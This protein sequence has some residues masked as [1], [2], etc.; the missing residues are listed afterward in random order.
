[1]WHL[2]NLFLLGGAALTASYK[3]EV[4]PQRVLLLQDSSLPQKS[5]ARDAKMT[6]FCSTTLFAPSLPMKIVPYVPGAPKPKSKSKAKSLAT[7][8]TAEH[9]RGVGSSKDGGEWLSIDDFPMLDSNA[10]PPTLFEAASASGS[11]DHVDAVDGLGAASELE[12]LEH[13]QFGRESLDDGGTDHVACIT[14]ADLAMV[15]LLGGSSRDFPLILE[16][17]EA[18]GHRSATDVEPS[19]G[20]SDCQENSYRAS[21]GNGGYSAAQHGDLDAVGDRAFSIEDVENICPDSPVAQDEPLLD[22]V[23]VTDELSATRK[24]TRPAALDVMPELALEDPRSSKRRR[25]A[26]RQV[27]K[28]ILGPVATHKS[29]ALPT[30]SGDVSRSRASN[31]PSFGPLDSGNERNGVGT[32]RPSPS[33]LRDDEDGGDSAHSC[34][35]SEEL[36]YS[37]RGSISPSERIEREQDILSDSLGEA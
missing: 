14:E 32:L 31:E 19:N 35:T 6:S 8:K 28:L 21:A 37:L 30:P 26:E 4:R 15:R 17:D 9:S 36:L 23:D 29:T 2:C 7:A 24:G 12:T 1:M 25:L 11:V 18:E 34:R 33:D 13:Y 10:S 3:A 22:D 5:P 16:S 20:A 27:E